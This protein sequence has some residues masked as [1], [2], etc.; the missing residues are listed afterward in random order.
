MA[1]AQAQERLHL[2]IHSRWNIADVQLRTRIKDPTHVPLR[3]ELQGSTWQ[4]ANDADSGTALGARVEG[5]PRLGPQA[6]LLLDSHL[7]MLLTDPPTDDTLA[8]SADRPP[9]ERSWQRMWGR[10]QGSIHLGMEPDN[11]YDTFSWA[12]QAGGWLHH[13]GSRR[14]LL[15]APDIGPAPFVDHG[16]WLTLR[17]GLKTGHT[18]SPTVVDL[19]LR[20]QRRQVD[21]IG[22]GHPV[23]GMVEHTVSAAISTRTF[24]SARAL[25]AD[26]DDS[27]A[28]ASSTPEST[29]PREAMIRGLF[30]GDLL[31]VA[32]SR[33]E[34]GRCEGDTPCN[35]GLTARDAPEEVAGAGASLLVER[36]AVRFTEYDMAIH[37]AAEQVSI[38]IDFHFGIDTFW[39]EGDPDPHVFP[40]VGTGFAVQVGSTRVAFDVLALP[41]YAPTGEDVLLE[42]RNDI[43]VE[44]T[45]S[46]DHVGFNLTGS[47]GIIHNIRDMEYQAALEEENIENEEP[48]GAGRFAQQGQ[49]F[50]QSPGSIR[51]GLYGTAAYGYTPGDPSAWDPRH[52]TRRWSNEAGLFL[53]WQP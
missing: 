21:Y 26:A 20:I 13:G 50:I 41:T 17:P 37:D 11:P 5:M 31:S 3:L 7:S 46:D 15:V 23:L 49:L 6:T 40:N 14:N 25:L 32:Y 27:R 43:M 44:S 18:H 16:V 38:F 36:L 48:M 19:P 10:H 2:P 33:A 30:S 39:L 47:Y 28:A 42:L 22:G 4:G 9:D 34:F 45:W 53:T 51:T 1:N 12:A 52:A 35:P 8:G 29:S 24:L